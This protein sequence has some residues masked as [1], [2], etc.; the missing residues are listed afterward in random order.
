MIKS[1]EER[2]SEFL[3]N[4]KDFRLPNEAN[5]DTKIRYVVAYEF[6]NNIM[7][8]RNVSFDGNVFKLSNGMIVNK[9]IALRRAKPYEPKNAFHITNEILKSGKL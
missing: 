1:F 5:Y 6:L 4:F 7:I 8:N 2:K 9:I 3:R